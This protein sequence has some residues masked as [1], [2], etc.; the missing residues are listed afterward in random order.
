MIGVG[1]IRKAQRLVKTRF[2]GEKQ[3]VRN[4]TLFR[5]KWP[6]GTRDRG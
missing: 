3:Y 1:F 6:E 2:D 5:S 4:I